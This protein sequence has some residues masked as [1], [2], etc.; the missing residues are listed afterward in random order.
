MS[1]PARLDANTLHKEDFLQF[2]GKNIKLMHEIDHLLTLL[3]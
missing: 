1:M 3:F 2:L